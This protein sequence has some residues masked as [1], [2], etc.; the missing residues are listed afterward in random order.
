MDSGVMLFGLALLTGVFGLLLVVASSPGCL[1]LLC[2]SRSDNNS[3]S[4]AVSGVPGDGSRMHTHDHD[5]SKA[6]D[7]SPNSILSSEPKPLGKHRP[8]PSRSILS[9]GESS[10][11]P[12]TSSVTLVLT[13][14]T[15]IGA[16]SD[17]WNCHLPCNWLPQS[18]AVELSPTS[19]LEPRVDKYNLLRGGCSDS[20]TSSLWSTGGGMYRDGGEVVHLA[21]RSPTEGGDSEIGGDGDGVVMAKSLT[22]GGALSLELELVEGK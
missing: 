17:L 2:C 6:P 8:H 11:P 1:A 12:I 3:S 13:S 15:V 21:R 18:L 9:P 14:P 20:G 19:Y 4:V 10:Y 22:G 7:E 16:I 5:G